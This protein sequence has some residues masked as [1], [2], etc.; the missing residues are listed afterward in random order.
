[1]YEIVHL[2]DSKLQHA[3]HFTCPMI[4]LVIRHHRWHQSL[5]LSHSSPLPL[6]CCKILAIPPHDIVLPSLLP[7]SASLI[8]L[9]FP[10]GLA[11]RRHVHTPSTSFSS[12]LWKAIQMGKLLLKLVANHLIRNV[13]L[14]RD[15]QEPFVVSHL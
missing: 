10:G 1:M 14:V 13:I 15:I 7:Y 3:H 9:H 12:L 2:Q 5:S 6:R 8:Y 4:L 11:N